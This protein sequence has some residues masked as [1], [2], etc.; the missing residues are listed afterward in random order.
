M[1]VE[2]QGLQTMAT[3][4]WANPQAMWDERFSLEEPVYGTRPNLY[5]EKHATRL[6]PGGS[7]L[8][9]GDGYGRNGHWLARQGFSVHTVDL[10]PVGVGRSKKAAEAAGLL[11]TIEQ[12]DLSV[13]RW[14]VREFDGLAAIFLHL[15]REISNKI[16]PA[17]LRALKPGGILIIEA[18]TPGQLKF[19]TGGPKDENLLYTANLLRQDFA[20]AE[21]L[22]LEEIELHMDEGVKHSGMSAIVHG[23]FRAR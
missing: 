11:L 23:V 10:S 3:D 16:H 5:L 18:F 9:P 22:E 17:M 4:N 20:G 14:P 2:I 21:I 13:W 1:A 12:A 19:N 7:V 8:V 6:R 15:P